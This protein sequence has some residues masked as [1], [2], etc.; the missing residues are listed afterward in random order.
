MD[1]PTLEIRQCTFRVSPL[2]PSILHAGIAPRES[3]GWGVSVVDIVEP[4]CVAPKRG[5]CSEGSILVNAV[6]RAPISLYDSP[7]IELGI[8]FR[9]WGANAV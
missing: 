1:Y 7:L 5:T 2:V 4:D 9:A 8:V 3:I 6:I